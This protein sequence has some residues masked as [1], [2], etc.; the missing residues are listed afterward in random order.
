[1]NFKEYETDFAKI[2]RLE[3]LKPSKVV[4]RKYQIM[5]PFNLNFRYVR[6]ADCEALIHGPGV[7][8]IFFFDKLVYV[9]KFDTLNKGNVA[10]ERWVKH[11]ETMTLRGNHVGFPTFKNTTKLLEVLTN[12]S[13][14]ESLYSEMKKLSSRFIDTGCVTSGNRVAFANKHWSKFSKLENT[15]PPGM[16]SVG[17]YLL[18]NLENKFAAEKYTRKIE[19]DLIAKYKPECNREY[20]PSDGPRNVNQKN[21]AEYTRKL[22][23]SL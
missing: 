1:M 21:C 6:P 7:Y 12:S 10:E 20:K 16:F 5:W 2:F 19:K 11:L 22:I 9:G 23:Q 15:I 14:K 3:V 13:L 18:T 4:R 17:Y 8:Q